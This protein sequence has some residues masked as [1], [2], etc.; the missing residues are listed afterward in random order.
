MGVNIWV[1][2]IDDGSM[3][4]IHCGAGLSF[5]LGND[6]STLIEAVG[7]K[8]GFFGVRETPAEIAAL[9]AAEQRKRDRMTIAAQILASTLAVGEYAHR[10]STVG[11]V[12]PDY[13]ANAIAHADVLLSALDAQESDA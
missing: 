12:T 3:R 5:G 13:I 9:I 7:E 10:N 8:T 6:G 4:L 11:E 1:T 2:D